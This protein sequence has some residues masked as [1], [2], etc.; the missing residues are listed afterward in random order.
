MTNFYDA[1]KQTQRNVSVTENGNVGYKTTY[2]PLLDFNFKVSSYRHETDE[3]VKRDIKEIIKSNDAQYLLKYLFM[4][5]DVRGGLGERR[6]FRLGLK[7]L[8][9]TNFANKSEIISDLI[10]TQ[11]ANYGR[12]DDLFL[13]MGT[14]YQD[15]LISTV[16]SQL[17]S[18]YEN[19]V[20]NK[21]VS[22]LAKW[23]P[24]ENTSSAQTKKL[25]KAFIK[26]FGSTSKEYRKLLSALRSYLKVTEVYTSANEWG[27]INYNQVPSKANLKYKD[28]FLKH[29]E[30]RRRDYLAALR[31]GVDKDGKEVKINSS[32]NYPHEVVAKYSQANG[33]WSPRVGAYDET[34]E[35]LWKNLKDKKGLSNT[36]VVRDGSGSMTSS[37]GN[38]HTITALHVST[39]LAIY[40]AERLKGEF[41]NKF[42][43]FSRRCQVVDLSDETSLHAKLD[44]CEKYD[45]CSNT[46]IANVFDTILNTAIDH[47]MTADEMPKQ[48]LIISDMEFDGYGGFNAGANVFKIA[49]Q[50]FKNAGY[51]LPKLVFWNVNSRTNTIPLKE[52]ENG[53]ILVSGF[54][55]NVLDMVMTGKTSPWDALVERIMKDDYKVIPLLENVAYNQSTQT[56]TVAKKVTEK[57]S[58]L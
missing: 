15:V 9:A 36:I 16:H 10:K 2:H 53:V 11:I 22:L 6:L 5:R 17:K 18:D 7:E 4:L 56:K 44:V 33:W 34:L 19:M 41:K 40:C 3:A 51:E 30:E 50:N 14:D 12:F 8:M 26:A 29:D 13:F 45:D 25:A 38:S 20:N 27:E 23:M 31:V 57:P 46:N 39:A 47:H 43:T 1:I 32:V 58:W 37:I 28:A 55:A 54:S 42:L 24:S 35:Q 48:I 21:P 49:A 52:N